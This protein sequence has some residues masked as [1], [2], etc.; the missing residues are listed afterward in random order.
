M[1]FQSSCTILCVHQQEARVLIS[2]CLCQH[3][4]LCLFDDKHPSGCELVSHCGLNCISL[5]AKDVKHLFLY[6]LVICMSSLE[7]HLLE[8]FAHIMK[9]V[10]FLLLSGRSYRLKSLI[11]YTVYKNVLPHHS[12]IFFHSVFSLS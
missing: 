9:W 8:S 11:R 5:M 1:V 2:P 6:L 12:P 7:K 10:V 3:L 4:L